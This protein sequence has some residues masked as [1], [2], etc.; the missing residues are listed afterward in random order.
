MHKCSIA[1]NLLAGS[2]TRKYLGSTV[3]DKQNKTHQCHAA[4]ENEKHQVL[5]Y[6]HE[7]EGVFLLGSIGKSLAKTLA[8]FCYCIF[9][10]I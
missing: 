1:N 6:K 10:V 4:P 3:N 9:K 5:K 7:C 2:S 8:K